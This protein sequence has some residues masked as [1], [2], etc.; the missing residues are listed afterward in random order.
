[1]NGNT[2]EDTLS[3][4]SQ[5]PLRHQTEPSYAITRGILPRIQFCQEDTQTHAPTMGKREGSRIAAVWVIPIRLLVS[6]RK[7]ALRHKV[8]ERN[9]STLVVRHGSNTRQSTIIPVA[10]CLAAQSLYAL[11]VQNRATVV[12]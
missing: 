12:P 10:M 9:V 11:A 7:T 2:E 4:L 1:M 3:S 8:L 5:K 6:P